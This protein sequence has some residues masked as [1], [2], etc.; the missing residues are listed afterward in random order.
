MIIIGAILIVI[1]I[2]MTV[3]TA[4]HYIFFWN[5]L[6]G[7]QRGSLQDMA[8]Y[9]LPSVSILV[10]MRNEEAVAETIL[11]RLVAMDYP[12][13]NNQYEVIAIDDNSNDR[14]GLIIDTFAERYPFIK[15]VHRP[16]GGLGKSDALRVGTSLASNELIF[17]FDADYQPTRACIKR[18]TAPFLDPE[19]GLVMGRVIPINTTQSLMTRLLDLERSGGYQVDQQARHNLNLVPQYGGTVGGIRKNIL[20]KLG[21]WDVNKLAE[22]TD[23]TIRCYYNGWRV[24]YVNIAEC[25]EESVLSWEERRKQLSRWA[26]GHNQCMLSHS[27]KVLKTPVLKWWQKLD[28]LLLLG[29]YMVPVLMLVG[30]LLSIVVYFFG[31]YWWW[32]LFAAL[33]FTLAYNNAGNFAS[34]NEV[35]V[36]VVLDK[37]GRM[38]WLLPWLLFNF[39]ANI[40]IC[41]GAFLKSLVIHSNNITGGGG[42]MSKL[43]GSIKWDKTE[44]DGLYNIDGNGSNGSR[45]PK[46][47]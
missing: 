5:R 34:F 40:W 1:F 12:K 11:K 47:G 33:L 19:V 28:G 16:D 15:A 7:K 9:Y 41:T 39:F 20:Q 23:I 27:S 17:V 44:K 46:K 3:Y 31:A 26:V 45:Y 37:R 13:D 29:V 42:D 8:G 43:D 35:G 4:R 22:D 2:I 24:T 10:P 32:L 36:S 18:L 30:L 21:G 38:L 14:T 25:Y 6:F